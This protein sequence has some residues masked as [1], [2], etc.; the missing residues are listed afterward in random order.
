MLTFFLNLYQ[1]SVDN[2]LQNENTAQPNVEAS[3]ENNAASNHSS[4]RACSQR[5][6]EYVEKGSEAQVSVFHTI[7]RANTSTFRN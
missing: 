1:S 2:H 6:K 3:S 5:N 4:D 7:I